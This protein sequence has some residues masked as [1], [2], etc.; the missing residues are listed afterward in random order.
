MKVEAKR[1]VIEIQDD[2]GD[3][4]EDFFSQV[5]AVE[6]AALASSKRRRIT[7]SLN[8]VVVPKSLADVS[9]SKKEISAPAAGDADEGLYM[10]AL[11]GNHSLVRQAAAA[12]GNDAVFGGGGGGD[13]CFKCG[14]SGHWARDCDSAPG[15]GGGGGGGNYGNSDPSI[16]EKSCPCGLGIC[17]VL[18]AN[19]EKNRGRKFYKCPLRQVLFID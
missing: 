8:A 7:P 13:S 3:G 12:K 1:S 10:A 11:K 17:T 9:N 4:D 2:D 5:A 15:G 19:T 16:P 18:T 6:A 14:K